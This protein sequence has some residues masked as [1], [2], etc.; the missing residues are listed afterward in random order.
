MPYEKLQSPGVE[1][2]GGGTGRRWLQSEPGSR[3]QVG[4]MAVA[5]S[6]LGIGARPYKDAQAAP[7]TYYVPSKH[8]YR[9][10]LPGGIQVQEAYPG[11][12]YVPHALEGL[13]LF[14]MPG[15][16][17]ALIGAAVGA[18]GGFAG[19]KKFVKNKPMLPKKKKQI[20]QQ[21]AAAGGLLGAI[22]GYFL[23][24]PQQASAPDAPSTIRM[25]TEALRPVAPIP[26]PI[27]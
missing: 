11:Q 4:Q 27:Y 1:K 2:R 9:A 23:C 12:Y 5:P 15:W 10:T 20:P 24:G 3:Q 14:N 6:W 19:G 17:C 26:P 13:P 18:G 7:G 25:P 16:Q 8:P 21:A 22:I